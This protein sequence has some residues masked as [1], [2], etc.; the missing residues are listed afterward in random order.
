MSTKAETFAN[1]IFAL[2]VKPFLWI[3]GLRQARDLDKLI[4][5]YNGIDHIPLAELRAVFGEIKPSHAGN[6]IT[7]TQA[8]V[9]QLEAIIERPKDSFTLSQLLIAFAND[10]IKS[11]RHFF[12]MSSLVS[13]R[14]EPN[15]VY[16]FARKYHDIPEN[17]DYFYGQKI[18]RWKNGL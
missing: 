15:M 6:L 16:K 8:S 4:A 1:V 2:F 12:D 18:D 13:H 5:K 7:I 3:K 11:T 17:A 14:G 10:E 9:N